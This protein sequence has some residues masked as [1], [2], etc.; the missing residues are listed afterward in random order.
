MVVP[1]PGCLRL[2]RIAAMPAAAAVATTVS[3]LCLP[4]FMLLSGVP[5]HPVLL[6]LLSSMMALL[7][8]LLVYC[9]AAAAVRV[10]RCTIQ[11]GGM[12]SGPSTED[13]LAWGLK[14]D[15]A[16][17]LGILVRWI[18]TRTATHQREIEALSR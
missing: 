12:V 16:T 14:G 15:R 2:L 6:L 13:V 5:P 10:R 4:F 7:L 1:L 17:Q 8:L 18:T 11:A 3:S 9:A